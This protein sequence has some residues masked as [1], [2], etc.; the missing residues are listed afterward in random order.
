MRQI[1]QNLQTGETPLVDAPT[2]AISK[3]KVLIQTKNSLI[4]T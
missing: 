1:L 4:S 3:G 2:P